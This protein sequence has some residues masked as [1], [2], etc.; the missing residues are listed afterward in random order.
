[1][2]ASTA[3]V[4]AFFRRDFRLALAYPMQFSMQWVSIAISVSGAYFISKLIPNSRMFGLGHHGSY[5]EYAVINLAFFS[6][7]QVT[8]TSVDRAIRDDQVLGTIEATLAS[9]PN[10]ATYV[11]ASMAW[12]LALSTAQ[13]IIYLGLA[14]LLYGGGQFAHAN[15][16]LT[17]VCFALIVSSMVPVGVLSACGTL[18]LK[19]APANFLVGGAMSFICGVLF[20]VALLPLPLRVISW[21]IPVTH[22]LS[23]MRAA[24]HGAP[25]AQVSGD[26]VWLAVVSI[27][28]LPLSL[29][30]FKKAVHAE[31]VAGTLAQY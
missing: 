26:L 12:P 20:P 17:L 23:A 1:M 18:R 2:I 15:L 31:R 24:L 29:L 4:G 9:S 19:S 27:L 16:P 13:A 3:H 14:A 11:L 6:I 7:M 22:A 21:M 5:F 28:G 10:V 30:L 25:F 8:M